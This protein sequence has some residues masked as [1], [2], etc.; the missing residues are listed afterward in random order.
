M[1]DTTPVTLAVVSAGVSDPSSTRLLADRIAQKAVDTL[2]AGGTPV[3]VT[4][5]DL[6]PIAVDIARSLVSGF[7]NEAVQDAIDQLAKADAIIARPGLQS[8]HQRTL[9]VLRRPDR[10]RPADRQAGDPRRHR[11]NSPTRDGRRR[12]TAPALRLPPRHPDTYLAV[13]RTRG[14]GGH[15]ARHP[16]HPR[17]NKARPPRARRRTT[18]HRRRQLGQ[19]PAPVRRPRHPCRAAVD[20]IDFDSDLMR[21]AAGGRTT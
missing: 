6:G 18:A 9:Q 16:H 4:R 12:A 8:R 11:R 15:R 3:T 19:P 20:D 17:R 7:P 21:L 1:S 2:R 5:I 14:L 13:R 10:Q